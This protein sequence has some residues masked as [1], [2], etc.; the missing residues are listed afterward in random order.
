[1]L[2]KKALADFKAMLVLQAIN[3][4]DGKRKAAKEL[5]LS[6]DT[7]NKYIETLEKDCGGKLINST[8][9]G[10]SLTVRGEQVA[11]WSREILRELNHMYI[12]MSE[13]EELKGEVKILWDENARANTINSDLWSYLKK[14]KNV[15]LVSTTITNVNEWKNYSADLMVSNVRWLGD[16]W[17]E[18]YSKKIFAGYFASS[19]YLKKYG[20]PK[21]KEDMLKNH[22]VMF[23]RDNYAWLQGVDD[24]IKNAS[25]KVYM[26]DSSFALNEA[27]ASGVGIGLMPLYFAKKGLV[28]LE[29]IESNAVGTVYLSVHKVSKMVQRVKVMAEHLIAMINNA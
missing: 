3:Q 14:N 20:Y 7:I 6:I 19:Q 28:Y 9:S 15:T 11:G 17:E 1:M 25:H 21:D 22:R 24:D 29:N 10:T 16:E 23:L 5:D 26:S 27:I 12:M 8:G 13:R 4:L 18:I 2:N